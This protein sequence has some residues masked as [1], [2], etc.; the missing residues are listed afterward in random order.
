V[1]LV[2]H[3]DF[4][5]AGSYFAS[6]H[7]YM[8]FSKQAFLFFL[9]IIAAFSS[10]AQNRDSLLRLYNNETIRRFG[11]NFQKGSDRLSFSDLKYEFERS[12][13]GFYQYTEAK[14]NRTV[15]TVL[16]VFSVAASIASF[17]LVSGNNRPAT[18]AFLGGQIALNLTG[19]YFQ[20]R[21]NKALDQAL[22][23][24]NKDLLLGQ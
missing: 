20:D 22:W 18:Y 21:S 5:V 7:S 1:A 24:R 17:S 4:I 11:G 15:A 12:P 6:K 13:M 16:R 10:Y 3:A 14:K 2:P 23:Q 8:S 9:F 19:F